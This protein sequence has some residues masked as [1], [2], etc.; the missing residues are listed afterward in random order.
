M[1]KYETADID[2]IVR[3]CSHL[4]QVQQNELRNVLSKYPKLFYNERGTYPDERI[5][6]DLKDDAV[7]HCQPRAYTVPINHREVFK[8]GLN[9]LVNI[10]VLEEASRSEWIEG[11][12]IIPKKLLPGKYVARV[13][14]ISDFRGLNRCLKRK[15]YPIPKTGDI[16]ARQTGYQFLTKKDISMQYHTFELD[17][18]S[19][20]RCTI[21]TPFGLYKYRKMPM[22]IK[23]APDIA[24]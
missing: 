8:T 21:A 1:S 7:P 17:K 9:R 12:F 5:H 16:L 19:S 4:N 15:T 24:Q 13:R 10:G 20:E 3:R 14:W 18:K 11:T 2:E 6:L 22:G 23:Q